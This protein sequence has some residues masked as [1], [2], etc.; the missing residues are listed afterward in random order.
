MTI[1]PKGSTRCIL[2][3]TVLSIACFAKPAMAQD[4]DERWYA[5]ATVGMGTLSSSTLSYANG[6]SSDTASADFEAS[7]AGGGTIGYRLGS[8]WSVEA[9]I[10]YRR[11]DLD[12]IDVPGLG[13]FTEG[14]FASLG[15][16]VNT[17]YRFNIGSSG[18]WSGYIGPGFVYLQE[19]DIDFDRDGEQEIS[20]ETDDTALQ[21]K[22]GG[23]YDF[24]ERWFA[25]AGAT[26]L[27]ASGVTMELPED[28]AQTISSDYDH[29]TF[30]L[31]AG[32]RF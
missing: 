4:V 6:V 19:I 27:T 12:P 21:L 25:E 26:Y 3:M 32:F 5:T 11:N 28:N 9:E 14:D 18:K 16:G 15:F 17:L 30:Q 24:S 22:F 13:S 1:D 2:A 7:F 10:M 8:R 29:W 31:G 20:F 23:R